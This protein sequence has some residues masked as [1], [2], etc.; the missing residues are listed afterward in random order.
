M[1]NDPFKKGR[2]LQ[3]ICLVGNRLETGSNPGNILKKKSQNIDI[4]RLEITKL[5]NVSTAD[6]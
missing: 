1:S 6:E 3:S 2:Y 4:H 5:E